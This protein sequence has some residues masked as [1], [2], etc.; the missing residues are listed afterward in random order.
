MSLLR[1]PNT[2]IDE[3]GI[4]PLQDR[5]FAALQKVYSYTVHTVSKDQAGRPDLISFYY[6]KTTD[7]WWAIM[8]FNGITDPRDLVEGNQLKIPEYQQILNGLVTS[9]YQQVPVSSVT[10]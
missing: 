10:L 7:L 9:S 6:Y 2:Y 4:D 5:G 1:E 8:V 3:Y